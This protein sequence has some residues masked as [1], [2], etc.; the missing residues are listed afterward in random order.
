MDLAYDGAWDLADPGTTA[1][2]C[3]TIEEPADPGQDP[4]LSLWATEVVKAWLVRIGGT[5]TLVHQCMYGG[6]SQKPTMLGHTFRLLANRA[7][8]CSGVSIKWLAWGMAMR[9]V[10]RR[11]WGYTQPM[12]YLGLRR[13]MWTWSK[14]SPA[15]YL[16]VD[17][18]V[19]RSIG[20]TGKPLC[21]QM[22]VKAAEVLEQ[23][24]FLVPNRGTN[25]RKAAGFNLH[26]HPSRFMLPEKKMALLA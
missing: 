11:D 6:I 19:F 18:G 16:H 14:T 25:A 1:L 8:L 13:P 24:G 17:D 5:V 12:H 7:L 4:F 2:L 21:E 26:S 23:V 9:A 3:Q 10:E 22:M 20:E 15:F